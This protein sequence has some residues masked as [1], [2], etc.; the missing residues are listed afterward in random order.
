MGLGKIVGRTELH[1]QV[2]FLL[3]KTTPSEHVIFPLFPSSFILGFNS[4]Q[5]D[6]ESS[7]SNT[8]I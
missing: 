5:P 1:T 3:N 8:A 2:S 7:Q 4:K 6:F